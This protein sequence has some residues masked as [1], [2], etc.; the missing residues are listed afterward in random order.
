VSEL[1][2][3]V[4]DPVQT[5]DMW[6]LM[7][8]FRQ[9]APVARIQ[10]NFVYVA[11]YEDARRVLRDEQTFSNVGGMRPTGLEIPLHDASIGELGPP[12]HAPARKLATTAAQGGG[13]LKRAGPFVTATTDEL[14][15]AIATRGSGDLIAD[16][17]LP[18]TARLIGWL[19]GMPTDDCAQLADWAEEIML[20]PLTVTNQT[21]R[22]VGYAG[23]FPEFTQYLEGL[24]EVRL[25]E[26]HPSDDTIARILA[27][28]A[29]GIERTVRNVRMVLLNLLLG[30]TATTRDLIG[31]LLH[32]ILSS[33]NLHGQLASDRSLVPAAVEE[34]L[35]HK[36][37]VLYLIRTCTRE[38]DLGGLPLEAGQRVVVGIAS[39]NRD[40][41]LY[42]EPDC[43][44]ID[45]PSPPPHLSFGLGQH[46]CVGA[47]LARLEAR[48]AIDSLLDHFAPGEIR[49]L[50][51][52][53]HEWMPLPYMLGPVRL[54]VETTPIR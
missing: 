6:D 49:L 19:L 20:S 17:S 9:Q 2:F 45:R 48:A 52:F 3:D 32:E 27:A 42:D 41:A 38:V 26:T 8:A 21:E 29:E 34:S 13:V 53:E 7:R 5:H 51:N 44:R 31:N 40:E 14:M 25:N 46:F 12:V 11:R 36:P 16:Y 37:P 30:G 22:G 15:N 54:D 47:P 33:P 35:R 24:V 18:I 28:S 4:F 23:A 10:G 43:F 39:A 1:D 50:A